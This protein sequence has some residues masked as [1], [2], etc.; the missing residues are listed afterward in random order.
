MDLKGKTLIPLSRAQAKPPKATV[1]IFYLA[2]CP[3]SQKLTPE[4]NRIHHEFSARGVKIYMVHED[5]T[6]TKAEV[7]NE[8]K[9]F[10]LAPTILIDKWR[11][12]KKMSGVTISP[13]A[14]VYDSKFQP[15]YK[16]RINNLFYGL[17]K[18]RPKAT[19][20]DLRNAIASVLAGKAPT[21]SETQA[22]GCILP[23]S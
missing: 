18:M 17:G 7:A 8:A 1:L 15:R 6:L 16:G 21:P 13:E 12:Q 9:A 4:I 19:S 23:K 3:I 14:V 5:L 10:A 22:I 2:H 20:R 11:S